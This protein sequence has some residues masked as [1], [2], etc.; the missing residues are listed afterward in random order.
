MKLDSNLAWKQASGAISGNRDVLFALAGV[1]Y[2]LPGLA[3]SLLFPQP[4]MPAD[5]TREQ[6]LAVMSGYYSSVIP[7]LIPI[8]LFQAAGT[9]A[10]L[11]MLTDRSRPTVGE[12]IKLGLKGIVPYFLAQIILGLAIG[13]VGSILFGIGMLVGGP[14]IAGLTITV[15]VILAIYTAIR[16]SLVAPVIVVEGVANPIA[17]LRRSWDLTK[18]NA[19]RIALF[20]ALVAIAF[21]VVIMIATALVGIVATLA[22][23][24]ETS[25]TVVIVVS[26][27]LNTI[28]TVYFVAIIASIHRQ[29]AGPSTESVTTTFE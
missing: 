14:I 9:L 22:F 8:V 20:Y 3:V 24:Q 29:L 6:V 23:G 21:M 18:D 15:V 11:T 19:L 25:E 26:A 7:Y 17:A 5:P 28:M 27:L 12:A 10:L 13:L 2:L 4:E 16:T 1:F